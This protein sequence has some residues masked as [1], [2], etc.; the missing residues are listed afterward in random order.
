MAW[1]IWYTG[2][3]S[4]L[5][6]DEVMRGHGTTL[7]STW[8]TNVGAPG[9]WKSFAWIQLL[10]EGRSLEEGKKEEGPVHKGKKRKKAAAI[11]DQDAPSAPLWVPS[12]RLLLSSLS[13]CDQAL[14]A[15]AKGTSEVSAVCRDRPSLAPLVLGNCLTLTFCPLQGTIVRPSALQRSIDVILGKL[16]SIASAAQASEHLKSLAYLAS[17]AAA[18][19]DG[20]SFTEDLVDM[21]DAAIT[22]PADPSAVALCL[23]EAIAQQKML[24]QQDNLTKAPDTQRCV[25]LPSAQTFSSKLL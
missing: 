15:G 5:G 16:G 3:A 20:S 8:S 25:A 7:R 21:T 12:K 18:K 2:R 1:Q 4:S 22:P 24:V 17:T 6:A 23:T 14:A 19:S 9:C 10:L 11:S 13:S